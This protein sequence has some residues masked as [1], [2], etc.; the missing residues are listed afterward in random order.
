MTRSPT[1]A[2]PV[3][4]LIMKGVTSSA[5]SPVRR[6]GAEGRLGMRVIDAACPRRGVFA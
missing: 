2:A 1:R 4:G 3:G 6:V 5:I